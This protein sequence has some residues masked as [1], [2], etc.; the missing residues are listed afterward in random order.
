MEI[1]AQYLTDKQIELVDDM[2]PRRKRDCLMIVGG[3]GEF[4]DHTDELLDCDIQMFKIFMNLL[5][6]S[7]SLYY[8]KNLQDM[9]NQMIEKGK[10]AAYNFPY[11][12]TYVYHYYYGNKNKYINNT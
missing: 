11:R 4:W 10:F 6:V 3:I 9:Q 5:Q 1:L 2:Q 7:K 8:N 12:C